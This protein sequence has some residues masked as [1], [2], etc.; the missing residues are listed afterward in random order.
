MGEQNNEGAL[1]LSSQQDKISKLISSLKQT[2]DENEHEVLLKDAL[3]S[4]PDNIKPDSGGY[5]SVLNYQLYR[6][7]L[8]HYR[9]SEAN[10]CLWRYIKNLPV[11][12]LSYN[13]E[14]SP[15]ELRMMDHLIQVYF[16][17]GPLDDLTCIFTPIDD[18]TPDNTLI[19]EYVD[20]IKRYFYEA[21]YPT[22]LLWLYALDSSL[23]SLFPEEIIYLG[24]RID[25]GFDDIILPDFDYSDAVLIKRFTDEHKRYVQIE[26]ENANCEFQQIFPYLQQE[27]RDRCLSHSTKQD[28]TISNKV[29]QRE[30]EKFENVLRFGVADTNESGCTSFSDLRAS[31]EFLNAFGKEV[32]LN[33][34]Q[35]PFFEKTEV[36][37]RQFAGRIDKFMGDNV[38]CVFLNNNMRGRTPEEKEIEAI[39]NNLFAIYT[40]CQVLSNII[41]QEK[42]FE[43]SNLGLRSGVTYGEQ[44]LRS[45]LGNEILR[46][47]TVTGETV[48]LAARLE[49]ISIP[50]LI[51]HNRSYFEKTR[52]RYPQIR[53]IIEIEG[54]EQIL[55]STGEHNQILNAASIDVIR[56]YTLYHNIISNLEELEKAKFDIRLNDRF[57]SKLREYLETKYEKL[58]D[59]ETSKIYG[60]EGFKIEGYDF[61]FYYSY[62]NPKGFSDYKRIWLLPLEE[63]MLK[64]FDIKKIRKDG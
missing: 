25:N 57:Y 54:I 1:P 17:S 30:W 23:S 41:S 22:S 53:E 46:D 62:Y 55:N 52:E 33:K 49:H 15:S 60:Y 36:I 8:K 29:Y 43:N 34:V 56:K 2:N 21:N 63:K 38:M 59:E 7:A 6:Y 35:Q 39:L 16:Y 11:D 3:E 27:Y 20:W 47:F 40:L 37:S 26:G 64:E 18:N 5:Y 28:A 50:E 19:K 32:Y 61:K 42:D 10:I 14:T 58:V 44:I 45:N 12:Q 4:A 9:H 13:K 31:T 51:I 48:N 24:K